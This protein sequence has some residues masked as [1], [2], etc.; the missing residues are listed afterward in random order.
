MLQILCSN[1]QPFLRLSSQFADK[2]S[3]SCFRFRPSTFFLY[4]SSTS[5]ITQSLYYKNHINLRASSFKVL[6]FTFSDFKRTLGFVDIT[7]QK[8]RLLYDHKFRQSTTEFF[9][10]GQTDRRTDKRDKAHI[11]FSQLFGKDV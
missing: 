10:F 4:L 5:Q 3:F 8:R 7:E 11:R 2:Y 9:P 6:V 1:H